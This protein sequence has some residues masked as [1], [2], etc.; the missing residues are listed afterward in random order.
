MKKTIVFFLI[1]SLFIIPLASASQ[2]TM[3][4]SPSSKVLEVGETF[5]L[6]ITVKPG[7]EVDTVAIDLL[8]W[9]AGVIDCISVQKGDIF[10][11]PV[12]WMSG[13]INNTAGKLQ[14]MVMASNVP[15]TLEK[16]FCTIRFQAK[17]GG[18]TTVSIQESGVARNGGALPKDILNSCQIT[19]NPT[20]SNNTQTNQTEPT[21]NETQPVGNETD[22]TNDTVIPISDTNS[23]DDDTNKTSNEKVSPGLF[24]NIPPTTIMYVIIAIIII[25][26]FA[27]IIV[28]HFQHKQE[29]KE[30][31]EDKED[32][33]SDTDLDSFISNNFGA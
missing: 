10:D 33:D 8:K 16:Q 19:V 18:I 30:D 17:R 15:T 4:I 32:V 6:T 24:D 26:V 7:Q 12:I 29:D 2:T 9:N 25:S 11:N 21:D 22:G 31:D 13:K 5:N 20:A 23:T 28:R 3:Q 27:Y 1:A 14:Y